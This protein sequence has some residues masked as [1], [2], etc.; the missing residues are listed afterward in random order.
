VTKYGIKIKK[1]LWHKRLGF[2]L[3]RHQTSRGSNTLREKTAV[4]QEAFA[5][6]LLRVYWKQPRSHEAHHHT[7]NLHLLL[8]LIR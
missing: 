4:S 2:I 7:D 5:V 6:V 1:Q 8:A 3:E